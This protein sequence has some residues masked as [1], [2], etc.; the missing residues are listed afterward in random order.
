MVEEN[1]DSLVRPEVEFRYRGLWDL[2]YFGLSG[3]LWAIFIWF[4]LALHPLV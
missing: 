1:N 4:S 3:V 2:P